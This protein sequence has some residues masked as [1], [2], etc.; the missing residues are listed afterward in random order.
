MRETDLSEK[1]KKVEFGWTL[2]IV[3]VKAL[4]QF[5]IVEKVLA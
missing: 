3:L 5:V 2:A 4:S 1:G